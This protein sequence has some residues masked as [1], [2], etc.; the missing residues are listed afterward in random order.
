MSLNADPAF[1][2]SARKHLTRYGPSFE[3]IIV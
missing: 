2:A 1:W 3:E